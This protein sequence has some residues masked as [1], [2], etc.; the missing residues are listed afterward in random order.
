MI[1]TFGPPLADSIYSDKKICTCKVRSTVYV[2]GNMIDCDMDDRRMDKVSA[3]LEQQ[4]CHLTHIEVDEVLC[5]VS[6]I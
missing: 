3:R 4:H 2:F 5:L 6:D 1:I